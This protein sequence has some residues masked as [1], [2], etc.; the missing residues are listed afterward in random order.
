MALQLAR[1]YA[2][3]YARGSG[4][5]RSHWEGG[6]EGGFEQPSSTF[7]RPCAIAHTISAPHCEHPFVSRSRP[8]NHEMR[9]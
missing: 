5:F 3:E 7:M 6:K 8:H 9:A 4:V 2:Q 1:K